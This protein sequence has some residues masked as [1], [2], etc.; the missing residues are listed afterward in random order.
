MLPFS[1]LN[2]HAKEFTEDYNKKLKEIIGDN[3]RHFGG[4]DNN[5][6]NE[7]AKE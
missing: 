7:N 1:I 3:D 5:L 6:Y 4:N 2:L